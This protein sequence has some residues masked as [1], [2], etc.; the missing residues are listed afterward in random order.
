MQGFRLHC[1]LS[2]TSSCSWAG[3]TLALTLSPS[4]EQA[5]TLSPSLPGRCCCTH[6][7][8]DL[9]CQVLNVAPVGSS[10]THTAASRVC[11]QNVGRLSVTVRGVS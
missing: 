7:W 10:R 1:S 11:V 3:G 5:S 4:R 9:D 2:V 8:R 6:T